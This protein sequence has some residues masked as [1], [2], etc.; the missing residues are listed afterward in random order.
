MAARI[1]AAA[2]YAL[3]VATL[4]TSARA[5]GLGAFQSQADIGATGLPG[6]ALFDPASGTYRVT[7]G[8]SNIWGDKDSFHFAWTRRSGDLHFAADIAWVGPGSDPHRKAGLMIRQN[9]TPGSPFA[10][11]MF[12]GSGLASLQYR[13]IEGG[14]VYEIM[15]NIPFPRRVQLERE[16]RYVYISLAGPDGVLRHAGGN[17]RIT[18]DGPYLAG[19]GV[20]AHDNA[21]T[22]TAVFTHVTLTTPDLKSVA[23]AAN[24]APV[25]ST[26]EVMD[27]DTP[28]RRRVVRTFAGRI[29]APNWSRDG[30]SLIYNADGSLFRLPVAG[31]EPVQIATGAEHRV[32]NDHGL[33]PDG[34]Q[35]AIS[36]QSEPDKASRIY[37]LPVQGSARPRLLVGEAGRPSYWHGWSPDGRTL[38]Y[39]A[40]RGDDG[41]FD[42]YTKALAGGPER[43]LT[44]TPGLDDGA[45][46]SPD[47]RYI[48]FNSERSGAMQIWRMR[49]GDGSDPEQV[50]RDASYRDWFP[51]LSPDG[52]WLVFVSF[53]QDV[54]LGEHPPNRDVDIRIMPADGSAP[55]HVLTRFFG[56]QGSMNVASWSPDSKSVAFVSYRLV[57]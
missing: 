32:N 12:H 10:D 38:A 48:Y 55:P 36:D 3:A 4:G 18:L 43:R 51:H 14:P 49:G 6:R 25:E 50:T 42:I 13:D 37:V 27:V 52:R 8:G 20:S 35:L 19:L 47:G 54:A 31:G 46:Y 11:V 57:R 23:N 53:G 24:G 21:V 29:E 45:E 44:R 30:A 7:G 9:L 41:G 39:V 33:S 16:G 22:E 28:F 1:F 15:S 2:V 26:L 5:D 40:D 56:G 34:R 17:Y